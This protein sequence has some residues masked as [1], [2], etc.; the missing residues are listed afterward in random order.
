MAQKKTSEAE[1]TG[2]QSL[3]VNSGGSV[4]LPSFMQDDAG[5]GKGNIDQ[6]DVVTPRVAL[7]AAISPEVTD[8]KGA[9]GNF[10]HTIAERDLGGAIDIVPIFHSKRY[11]LWKPRHEGGG[12]LA[13]SSDGRTWDEQFRNKTF[14]VSPDKNRPRY[15]VKWETGVKVGRDEGLGAWG[16]MDPANEDSAPAATL[17]QVIVA[18]CPS[19]LDLGPFVILLQRSGEPVA[20][21]LLSK[22]QVDSAPMFGQ[23]YTMSSKTQPNK[24]GDNFFNYVFTKNGHVQTVEQ[25]TRFREMHEAFAAM[26]L[27]FNDEGADGEG[28]DNAATGGDKD[29]PD[30]KRNF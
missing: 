5:K 8:G 21:Q 20:K 10:Y 18:V 3:A 9:A 30:T 28:D 2:T 16:T 19:M 22:I 7:L 23:M 25:Y 24:S 15:K 13:R 29:E 4:A 26:N 1:T 27:R 6:S 14:E 17:S 12:I 11:T